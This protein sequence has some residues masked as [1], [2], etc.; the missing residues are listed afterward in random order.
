[1]NTFLESLNPELRDAIQLIGIT[2]SFEAGQSV[3][4]RGDAGT[5]IYVIESGGARVHDGD[6]VL[7]MLGEGDVFGEIAGLG[8]TVRTASVTADEDLAVLRVESEALYSALQ[9]RPEALRGLIQMLCEREGGMANRMTNRSRQLQAAQQEMEIGRRIQAGFLPDVLPEVPGYEVAS[10]FQAARVVAGD[11]YDAF[12]IPSIDRLALVIGDVCDK[13]VGAAL[14]MTLFRSLIRATAQSRTFVTWAVDHNPGDSSTP[15]DQ[16]NDALV[17][18]TLANTVALTNNYVA[19]THG[20]TSM[21]ASVFVGLL[22]TK[23]GALDYVNA[24]HEEA[25]IVGAT[26][27]RL[28]LPPTGPV[29]GIFAGANHTIATANIDHGETILLYTDGV[30]EATSQSGEQF[31]EQR[32]LSLLE[33]WQGSADELL[34]MIVSSICEFT[35]GAGQHDDITMLASRRE[36]V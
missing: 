13:G 6:L 10:H 15:E 7:N 9:K 35:K 27:V 14:F 12:Y 4:N 36:S 20:K 1:M 30:P 33:S 24:G 25:Y 31:S 18:E 22:D 11:F 3:F 16:D 8:G 17:H 5:A 19:T 21:F 29:L 32:V 28:A 2:I 26:G 34:E 23:T